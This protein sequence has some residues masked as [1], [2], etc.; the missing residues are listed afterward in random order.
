VIIRKLFNN[1]KCFE[2]GTGVENK[3]DNKKELAPEEKVAGCIGVVIAGL[4]V[5]GIAW[6]AVSFVKDLFNNE[7]KI[8]DNPYRMDFDGDGLKGDKDDHDLYHQYGK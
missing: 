4:I 6:G 3:N 8:E 5:I 7:P 2:D 1:I